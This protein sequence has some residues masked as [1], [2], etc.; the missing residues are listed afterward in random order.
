M[1]DEI[2]NA[3]AER[4]KAF[5]ER[6]ERLTEDRKN[7]ADDISEVYAEAKGE[8]FDKA[9]LKIIIKERAADPS[10]LSELEAIT[11]VYRQAL[12]MA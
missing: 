9:A 11:E 7:I 2:T 12:G 8:G 4:L 1:T 10:A 3:T 5:V 6:I